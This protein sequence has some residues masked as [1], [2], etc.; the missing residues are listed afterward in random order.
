[1]RV[2]TKATQAPL[3]GA[4]PLRRESG[5][6]R[7]AKL[8]KHVAVDPTASVKN[9]PRPK[10]RVGGGFVPWTEEDKANYDKRWPLG[11]RQRVWRDVIAY[12][13]LRRGDVVRIGR[14]HVRKGVA[15]ITTEK[16]KFT[17]PVTLPILPVLQATLDAGPT[18]E[19]TFICGKKGRP[20]TKES[21]GNL[22]RKACDA[23]GVK[24]S[25]HGIRKI[26]AMRAALNGATVSQLNAIFGW[27]G[28]AMASLYTEAASRARLSSEAIDKL[29][30]ELPEPPALEETEEQNCNIY[31]LTS[32]GGEGKNA[33]S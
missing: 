19:L 12:T 33:K 7:W 26:A 13:G 18:G 25:A 32:A 30:G 23:A 1:M 3:G 28:S 6:F 9:P 15:Q 20:L 4:E 5:L 31:S 24:G 21:F 10:T 16:S 14:Q 8:A 29:L 27:T 22:F 17:M 2:W 11:T